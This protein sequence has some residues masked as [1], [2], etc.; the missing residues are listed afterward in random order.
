MTALKSLTFTTLPKIGANPTLDRDRTSRRT[1]AAQRSKLHPHRS[2]V[3]QEG[4]T[5]NPGRQ[6]A[7][8]AAVVAPERQ[9]VLR[10]LRSVRLE[11]G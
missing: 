8:R 5:A 10:V 9:Q 3:G 6:A 1:K 4:R 11:P 2:D 7:A